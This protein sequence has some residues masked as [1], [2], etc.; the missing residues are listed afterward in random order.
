MLSQGVRNAATRKQEL[1]DNG[2][3][4][5]WPGTHAMT[6]MTEAVE[7]LTRLTPA[8]VACTIPENVNQENVRKC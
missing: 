1:V 6:V 8:P 2:I 3:N 5:A 7:A 4:L